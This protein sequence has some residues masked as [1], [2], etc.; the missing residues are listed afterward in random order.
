MTV[1][2]CCLVKGKEITEEDLDQLPMSYWS[3]IRVDN[4]SVEAELDRIV[5]STAGQVKLIKEVIRRQNRK[6]ERRR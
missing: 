5:E 6:T 4:E 3:E 2:N 1:E